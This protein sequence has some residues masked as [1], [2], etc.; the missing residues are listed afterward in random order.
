MGSARTAAQ[1]QPLRLDPGASRAVVQSLA[2]GAGRIQAD[3]VQ[4]Q[5]AD[6]AARLRVGSLRVVFGG[7]FS[8]GKSSMINMLLSRPLLPASNYPETGVPC[9][10]TSGSSDSIYAVAGQRKRHVP[11]STAAIAAAVSLIGDDGDYR[12]VVRDVTRLDVTLAASPIGPGIVWV[13]SPGIN[14]SAGMTSRAVDVANEADVL[15]WVVNSRQPVSE[16]EQAVLR[17]HIDARGPASAVFIVNAFLDDDTVACWERFLADQAPAHQ[18]RIEQLIKTGAVAKHVIFA[19]ARAAA[20]EPDGFGGPEARAM[21]AEMTGPGYWRASATRSYQVKATLA[22]LG[23]DLDSQARKE[24]RRLAAQRREQETAARAVAHRHQAFLTAVTSQVRQV[25]AQQRDTADA[26][27]RAVADTVNATARTGDFYGQALTTGLQAVADAI[28][29]EMA[30]AVAAQAS[31]HGQAALSAAAKQELAALLAPET[32]TIS[33]EMPPGIGKSLAVGAGAGF[34]AGTVVPVLG[35]AVGLI[36]GAVI[37]GWRAKAV[38]DQ[39]VSALRAEVSQAGSA[40]ITAM[41][42][43]ADR[44]IALVKRSCPRPADPPGPDRAKLISLQE[45]RKHLATLAGA[46]PEIT[47][48][49]G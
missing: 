13:D 23:K 20:A 27:V 37:G 38:Q 48:S 39:R 17:D 47:G 1:R 16:V 33:S 18:A 12:A 31:R 36:S 40:A 6:D 45:A 42:G 41:C 44:I 24:E 14:D 3:R 25:L 21:L 34:A 35:H 46:L 43:S 11:F 5:L 15:I 7:H 2:R 49:A 4:Q 29:Q 26:A 19:S 28:T 32:I 22:R 30:A 9:A 8:C 10:L